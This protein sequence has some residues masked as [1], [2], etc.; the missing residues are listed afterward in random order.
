[1]QADGAKRWAELAGTGLARSVAMPKRT[2]KMPPLRAGQRLRWTIELSAED[3]AA[4]P[5]EPARRKK[6]ASRRAARTKTGQPSP[7]PSTD[8][9]LADIVAAFD[10]ETADLPPAVES[11]PPAAVSEPASVTASAPAE[12]PL[13]APPPPR[14]MPEMLPA[15]TPPPVSE[16]SPSAPT[17][18]ARSQGTSSR[19]RPAG[20]R[21]AL[22]LAAV[23]AVI[24]VAAVAFP[25]KSVAP[26]QPLSADVVDAPGPRQPVHGAAPGQPFT[27][28]TSAAGAV[29]AAVA[30]AVPPTTREEPLEPAAAGVD[31]PSRQ[32]PRPAARRSPRSAAASASSPRIETAIDA[33]SARGSL[34]SQPVESEPP[35]AMP[36]AVSAAAE[37]DVVADVPSVTITGCLEISVDHDEF[38]LTDTG[39]MAAPKARSWRSGFLRK[40]SAAVALLDA[41]DPLALKSHVGKRV[42]ASGVLAGHDLQVRSVQVVEGSCE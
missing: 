7:A 9:E 32:T 20:A 22:A 29:A 27:E 33:T 28:P 13:M 19:Q 6:R 17:G 3:G 18:P 10:A 24:I 11:A 23:A 25:R 15:Q 34:A 1:V 4:D 39:G 16:Q 36:T 26:A 41:P 5:Q 42:A 40:R 14:P 2:L 35:Q 31:E 12:I 37:T 8:R 30:A 38:R 21:P